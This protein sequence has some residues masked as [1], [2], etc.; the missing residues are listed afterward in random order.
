MLPIVRD[1]D[2]IV[3]ID[4]GRAA[5]AGTHDELMADGSKYAAMWQADQQLV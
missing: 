2:R 3:V 5:E 1:A 4:G